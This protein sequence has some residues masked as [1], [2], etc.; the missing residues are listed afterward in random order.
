MCVYIHVLIVW[1]D[2]MVDYNIMYIRSATQKTS[3]T[4]FS[5]IVIEYVD[6]ELCIRTIYTYV[7]VY[8]LVILKVSKLLHTST[9][10][11]RLI[12]IVIQ[13]GEE[14][15]WACVSVAVMLPPLSRVPS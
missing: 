12:I 2:N 9:K 15:Q 7:Y 13:K 10:N 1:H 11:G 3:I 14:C 6:N 4:C 5:S 8:L